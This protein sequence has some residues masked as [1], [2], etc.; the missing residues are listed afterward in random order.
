MFPLN[1]LVSN[2]RP[3]TS[4]PRRHSHTS[5]SARIERH[6][7]RH[8]VCKRHVFLTFLFLLFKNEHHNFWSQN[9]YNLLYTIYAR[10][11][12]GRIWSSRGSSIMLYNILYSPAV[13]DIYLH[14]IYHKQLMMFSLSPGSRYRRDHDV[15][16]LSSRETNVLI[17]F[18]YIIYTHI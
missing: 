9:P 8:I 1:S 11:Y 2:T 17:I 4:I 13:I 15:F 5:C 7:R 6:R 16:S 18:I 10:V 3:Y 14:Y 12:H